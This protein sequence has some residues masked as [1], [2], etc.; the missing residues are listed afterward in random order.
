MQWR[1]ILAY[2][3]RLKEYMSRL[4]KARY[5]QSITTRNVE[6]LVDYTTAGFGELQR[7]FKCPQ[8][9]RYH[10]CQVDTYKRSYFALLRAH[11]L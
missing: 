9:C 11:I 6:N 10:G 8:V 3:E 5:V 4:E 2:T 1:D 7:C